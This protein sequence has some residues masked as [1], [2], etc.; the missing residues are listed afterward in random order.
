MRFPECDVEQCWRDAVKMTNAQ[1]KMININK[2]IARRNNAEYF[3]SGDYVVF[4]GRFL[5]DCFLV[6]TVLKYDDKSFYKAKN[7]RVRSK[8]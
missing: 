6:F 4:C 7:L 8:K 2:K 5:P 1:L 3:I